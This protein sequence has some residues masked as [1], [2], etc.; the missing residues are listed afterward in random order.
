MAG[1][2]T[3]ERSFYTKIK[4]LTENVNSGYKTSLIEHVSNELSCLNLAQRVEDTTKCGLRNYSY[5]F[6]TLQNSTQL[7]ILAIDKLPIK[8]ITDIVKEKITNI[9]G[10]GFAIEVNIYEQT[11]TTCKLVGFNISW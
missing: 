11:M 8:T 1:G 10:D 9:I 7:Y 4:Q 6:T 2:S 3:V 5:K